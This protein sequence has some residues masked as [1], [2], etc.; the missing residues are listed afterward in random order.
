MTQPK[1][2]DQT[3]DIDHAARHRVGGACCV[4]SEVWAE[5]S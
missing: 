2:A 3:T 5:A 1:S 4:S